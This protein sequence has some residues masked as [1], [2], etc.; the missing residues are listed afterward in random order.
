M[1][2]SLPGDVLLEIFDRCRID[3]VTTSSTLP[4]NWHRLAHVCRTWRDIIL[5]SSRHLN[6]ELL[7]THGTPV[8]KYLG[9]LPALPIVIYFPDYFSNS[10]EDNILA[11][12]EHPA[13]GK[14][15]MLKF[16]GGMPTLAWLCKILQNYVTPTNFS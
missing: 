15:D 14:W 9:Y 2:N 4:W 8:R 6:L 3:E 7:C 10:D 1:I 16:A 5:S 11:A 12:L 13:S